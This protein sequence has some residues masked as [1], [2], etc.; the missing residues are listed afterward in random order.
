MVLMAGT[1]YPLNDNVAI[2]VGVFYLT[3]DGW[4][5]NAGNVSVAHLSMGLHTFHPISFPNLH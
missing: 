3:E 2:E 5:A 4:N 1:G